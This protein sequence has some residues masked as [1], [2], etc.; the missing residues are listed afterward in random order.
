MPLVTLNRAGLMDRG[1]GKF[2]WFDFGRVGV[3]MTAS[4]FR[5]FAALLAIPLVGAVLLLVAMGV[6]T[7]RAAVKLHRRLTRRN[8]RGRR[9]A[10]PS[11][12]RS[13]GIVA[14]II[15]INIVLVWG[16]CAALLLGSDRTTEF[17]NTVM[18]Y[19]I[20]IPLCFLA[21]TL[22]LSRLLPASLQMSLGVTACLVS[23]SAGVAGALA[24]EIPVFRAI[25]RLIFGF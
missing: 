17:T 5:Q 10:E 19:L 9:V 16:L 25:F 13:L 4:E 2:R 20:S 14:A 3:L 23:V 22:V 8:A 7:L 6:P 21:T 12:A 18:V 1:T 11:V 15:P 24:C